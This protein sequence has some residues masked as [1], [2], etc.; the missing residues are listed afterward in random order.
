MRAHQRQLMNADRPVPRYAHAH[1]RAHARGNVHTMQSRKQSCTRAHPCSRL[2]QPDARSHK[3]C[4]LRAPA[5]H[6]RSDSRAHL[7]RMGRPTRA[8]ACACHGHAMR[9]PCA[10]AMRVPRSRIQKRVRRACAPAHAH[11]CMAAC[12]SALPDALKPSMSQMVA[13]ARAALMHVRVHSCMRGNAHAL[14]PPCTA[15]MRDAR[16][17]TR[18]AC[19]H[20]RLHGLAREGAMPPPGTHVG[21]GS[22]NAFDAATRA[23]MSVGGRLGSPFP[24]PASLSTPVTATDVGSESIASLCEA[25]QLVTLP[26]ASEKIQNGL[27]FSLGLRSHH[28]ADCAAPHVFCQT[29]CIGTLGP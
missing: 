5:R 25:A 8:Y 26:S 7:T 13:L 28:A 27:G 15:R 21:G 20:A 23:R 2:A 24:K 3:G 4:A 19:A 22:A 16:P 17:R 12:A 6:A 10:C 14:M 11:A 9:A 29:S 18:H 1:A